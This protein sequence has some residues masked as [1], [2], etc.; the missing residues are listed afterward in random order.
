[1]SDYAQKARRGLLM[2]DALLHLTKV[3]WSK[4]DIPG[5][6]NERDKIAARGKRAKKPARLTED[7]IEQAGG[8]S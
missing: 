6:I 1:M 2:E 5:C 8:D 4:L 7:G 3:D